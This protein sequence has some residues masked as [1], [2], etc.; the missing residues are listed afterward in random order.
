M[1][2]NIARLR[3][4]TYSATVTVDISV[5]IVVYEDDI[6]VQKPEKIIPKV[7]IGHF[8]ILVKSKYCVSKQD[9]LSE[10]K[11]DVGGYAI[12]NGNEKVIITQEK[13]VP[14][15][16]QVY[17]NS[18]NGSKYSYISEVRSCNEKIFG[19]TKTISIK[20]TKKKSLNENKL[21]ISFPHIKQDIPLFIVFKALGCLTDKEIIYFIIDNNQSELD[22]EMIK[23]L[24]NS[25][26]DAQ[27]I[28]TEIDAIKYISKYINHINTSFTTE[29]KMN[30]TKSILHKEY[31]PHLMNNGYH[32]IYFTALMT[33]KLLKCYFGIEPSSDRD[34]YLNK[35]LEPCGVLLGNL[36]F[37]CM[38]RIVKEMKTF[39]TKEVTSGLWSVNKNYNDIVNEV[40]I[41]KIIKPGYIESVLKGA[42][43]TGSWG[44]KNNASKQGVSQV[45]V[46]YHIQGEYLLLL[47]IQVN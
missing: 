10:C 37:Q 20:I 17:Q 30:Y 3:N 19:P 40:N 42:M 1:T 24:K 33:N 38:N 31:L 35:R 27:D 46:H 9:P 5:E 26:F 21:Y 28:H 34:S 43:S 29:M 8:P 36:T 14:N 12:I 39:L 25:I 6:I 2:P 41:S 45:L 7:T 23:V 22:I 47:I 15:I 32:K 18:K 44:M 4:H 13:I 16:I 11:Y